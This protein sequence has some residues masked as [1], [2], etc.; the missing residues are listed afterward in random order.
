MHIGFDLCGKKP[1]IVEVTYFKNENGTIVS[2]IAQQCDYQ[3]LQEIGGLKCTLS[4]NCVL[5]V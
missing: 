1:H 4:K 2:T 5:F 3:V